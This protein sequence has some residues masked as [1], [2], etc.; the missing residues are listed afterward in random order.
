MENQSGNTL[1]DSIVKD[2]RPS[3]S[4]TPEGQPNFI[5]VSEMFDTPET[6][7]ADAIA[8]DPNSVARI[9]LYKTDIQKYGINAMASLGVAYP[10]FATDTYNPVAQQNPPD[11]TYSKL[12]DAF[13]LTDTTGDERVA[14]GFAGM[15]QT[16]FMRYY[17]HPDFQ[18]LGFSPYANMEQYYN[19]NSTVYDDMTRMWGEYT[20]LAGSGFSSVYR[21]IGDAF[22]GDSYWSA[23]DLESASEFQD[24]MGIGNS[25]RNGGMA[26]TNNFLLN[27]AYTVGILSSIAVEELAMA[28][29]T[30]ATGGAFAP[31]AGVKSA[32]NLKKAGMAF[33]NFFNVSRMVGTTADIYRTL[34][35]AEHAKSFYDAA[36][37][38]GKVLG[39]MFAPN[40]MYAL[41]NLKSAENATQN[42]VNLA[43]MSST[44]GGF[45]RD[46]R[47]VNYAMAESKMEAGMVYN[48]VMREGINVYNENDIEKQI[49]D[50]KEVR[51]NIRANSQVSADEM[52][53]IR[54]K[55][56]KAGFYTQM[57]NAPIIYASNWFV[58]GNAL[59]GFNKSLG[60]MMNDSFRK[61]LGGKILKTK[62]TK[63]ATGA[64]NKNVFEAAGSGPMGYFRSLRAAGIKGNLSGMAGASLR[65]FSNNV[66]EG[67]Q[68]VSQEAVSAATK[69]YFNAVLRDPMAGGIEL[70]NQMISSGM[71]HQLSGE[72]FSV[73]MS[74]FLMGGAIQAPQ[75]LFFQGVPAVFNAA[76]GKF[77]TEEM[78][79]KY[80]EFKKNKT[81]LVAEAVIGWN[82]AWNSQ[83]DDPG[84][85]FDQ[86]KFNFLIQKQVSDGMKTSAY[87]QDMFGFTDEKD[88]GKFIQINTL[89]R[90]GGI[91]HFTEQLEDYLKLSDEEL[92][93]AFPGEAKDIANGKIRKR[94]QDFINYA[95]KAE[96]N[97]QRLNDEYQNPHDPNSFKKGTREF[98]LEAM[99][100]QAYEHA[101]FLALYTQDNFERA[102]ERS[103]SIF[104]NLE[105][106]PLFEKMAAKDISILTS[107]DNID[108]EIQLLRQELLSTIQNEGNEVK[109]PNKGV[110]E[111]NKKKQEKITRLE[112]I[113]EILT[114]PKNLTKNGSFDRR[115][116]NKLRPEFKNYVRYLASTEGSFLERDKI[117][118]A[119]KQLVDYHALKGRAQVYDKAVEYLSNPERLTE[120]ADRTLA[121]GQSLFKNIKGSV[122][123]SIEK[124]LDIT[125]AN[126]LMN[127]L[128]ALGVYPDPAES[129]EFLT[130]GDIDNLKTFYNENGQIN[131]KVDTVIWTQIQNILTT[132]KGITQTETTEEKATEKTETETAEETRTDQN[133]ILNELGIQVEL[134]KSNDTP[135]LNELLERQYRKYKATQARLGENIL[136]YDEWRNSEVGLN[137]QNT[138]NALKKVWAS[139]VVMRADSEGNPFK[140]EVSRDNVTNEKGFKEWFGLREVKESAIVK[141]ILDSAGLDITDI[142]E[143]NSDIGQEGDK[144]KGSSNKKIYKRGVQANVIKITTKDPDT[145]EDVVLYKL[146]DSNGKNISSKLLELIDSKFGAYTSASSAIAALKKIEADAPNTSTFLFDEVELHQGELLFDKLGN[147]FIVLST[148]KQVQGGYLRIIEEANNTSNIKEREKSVI[149][150]QAGQLKGRYSLQ[151]IKTDRLPATTSRLDINDVV[152]P[153][154]YK[155][156]KE[157]RSMAAQRYN[158]IISMLTPAE[159]QMLELYIIPN[160]QAGQLGRYYAVESADG[161]VYKESNPYIRRIKSKYDIGVR[162]ADATVRNRVNN[163]L[164]KAG[165]QLSEN[166][167]NIFAY[168]P[169]ES[170]VFTDSQGNSIDPR[171]L[172]KEQALN[173]IYVPK[174]ISNKLTKEE[175]LTL[176]Q[177]NFALNAM[178]VTELD[179]M[180]ITEPRAMMLESFPKEIGL[181]I[182]GA[183]MAY[184]PKEL[185]EA[186]DLNDLNYQHADT[187]GNYL[188]YDLKRDKGGKGRTV[189]S[190]TN[191]EGKAATALRNKVKLSLEG[192][193]QWEAMLSGTDRYL[194]AVLLPNGKYGLV[195]L[196]PTKFSQVEIQDL[197]TELIE[198]AQLTQKENLDDKGEAKDE[199]Y[200]IQYNSDLADRLFISTKPGFIVALQVDPWGKIQMDVFDKNAKKQVGENITIGKKIINDKAPGTSSVKKIQTLI[201]LFNKDTEITLAGVQV[202]VN[203]LRR[204]FPDNAS[205]QDVIDDTQTN[206]LPSVIENQSLRI[207]ASSAD[208]QSSRDVGATI[209]NK[210][211]DELTPQNEFTIAEEAEESI[212]DLSDAQF[213]EQ[214]EEE[215][216]NFEKEFVGHMVN[217]ILRGQELSERETQAYK[218]LE[219]RVNMEVAKAG[220]AGSKKTA[221]DSII[222]PEESS[223][224]DNSPLN[225]AKLELEKLKLK[226][227]EGVDGRSKRKVLKES[228][229]YQKLKEKVKKLGK[230][231]NKILPTSQLTGLQIE[232][233]DAFSAWAQGALPSFI[234]IQDLTQL[235]NNQKAGGQRV[236]AFVMSLKNIAGGTTI[237]GTIYTGANSPFKYHEA[238]HGV[239]TMLLSQE[240]IV[241]YRGIARKEVRAKLRAEGKNFKT[242]L[243]IFRN[244]ADTYT[245]MTEKELMNEYYEEYLAD[246]FEVFKMSPKKTNTSPE[247]KSLFTK[248]LEFIK[249]IFSTRSQEELKVL[250]ENIDA[251]KYQNASL[252]S[253]EFTQSLQEGITLEKNA[254]VPY[255]TIQNEND[256]NVRTGYL[257]LDSDIADPMVR[258]IAAMYLDKTSKFTQPTY[259]PAV[260]IDELMDD[261]AWMYSPSNPNNENKSDIQIQKLEEIEQ[262][263]DIYDEEIKIEVVELLNVLG[264]QVN[265]E[266]Y[267]LDELEDE[268][269]L[270]ST[271]QYDIDASMIGGHTSLSAKL[272]TY[273]ATTTLSETDYFGNTELK[274]GVTLITAVD[275][276]DAYNGLLKAV[277]NISDPKRILQSMYFFGQENAQAGAVVRRLL[278]DVGISTEELLST[279]SLGNLS[280]PSLLQSIIKGFENFRVDYIF[281]ERDEA[282]NIRIYSA[283]ERDDINSQLDRWNQAWINRS[284]LLKANSTR[285]ETTRTML[286]E[287]QT[288]LDVSK[289]K[290]TNANLT[291]I[292]NDFSRKLFDLVGVRLSPLYL[293]YS[294]LQQR[295]Q[296]T[297]KQKALVDLYADETPLTADSIAQMDL[298]IQENGDIF[299]TVTGMDS[300]L[301]E[302]SIH[303]APFDETIGA[304]VFKNPNG[305]LVYAHQK[306][307]LHLKAVNDLN[308]ASILED[309]KVSDPYLANNFLLNSTAFDNLSVENRLKVLRIAGSKVG[310]RLASEE[311]LN[312][313]ISGVKSTQTYGD[314]TSKEFALAVINNYAALLNTKSNKVQ[315]VS[316][317]DAKGNKF[318]RA[319]AP[320][321]IR[322][323]EASNTGD[324][325]SLPVIKAVDFKAGESI[326]SDKLINIYVD[327]VKTEFARINREAFTMDS[328][329]ASNQVL[330]Y[331]TKDGR[332]FKFV[333]NGIV[334]SSEIQSQL[335]AI[336]IREGKAQNIVSLETAMKEVSNM[337]ALKKNIRLN[338]ETAFDEF[339]STLSELNMLDEISNNIL[340]GPVNAKGVQRKELVDSARLLNLNYDSTHNLKQ[341]FFNDWVN[342]GAINEIL[343]GDQAVTLSSMVDRVKRAKM[344][345]AAYDSAYSAIDA[346]SQGV[347]HN[348]EKISLITLEEP[349]GS[350]S[351]TGKNIDKADAQMYI[352]TKAFRYLRFGFGRLSNSQA[353][354]IDNIEAGQQITSEDIFG[355]EFTSEGFAKKQELLNSKKLV[356][357]DGTTFL[358][359]SAFILTPEY[360]SLWDN[361]N[362]MWVAKPHRV[363]LHNLRVKLEAIENEENA[364]TLGIAAPLTAIKM[365]K[366]RVNQLVELDNANPFTNAPT[367]LDAR[368]MGLQVINKSNKLEILDTTQI[369]QI[370]TSEQN[371]KTYVEALK[372]NVGQIR[373]AYNTAV[374]KRVILNYK[375]KRNLVFTLDTALDELALSEKE[376]GVTP[377]LAA[378]LNYAKEGLKA[379]K[380]SQ[381]I[382]DFFSTTDGVQNYDL[383]NPLTVQK[384]EQLFLAYFSRG[385]LS[386][387]APGS[388]LTLLS[389]FGSQIYR[390]VYEVETKEI[391][392]EFITTPVR[393]EVI[394]ENDFLKNYSVS[395]LRDLNTITS[396]SKGLSQG[397]IV[398]DDLRH[399]LMEYT[400][401][402]DKESATG[403]RYTEM[404]MPAHYKSVMDLIENTPNAKLPD[405]I[406]KMFGVR[407]PSQDNHSAVNM[408]MVDFMP[409]YYGSTAMFAQELIE[410]SGADFDIDK[411][412]ALM[413]EFYVEEGEFKEYGTG[414]LYKEYINYTN[415]KANQYGTIYSEALSLFAGNELAGATDLTD[416]QIKSAKKA[417]FENRTIKALQTLGLPITS[418]QFDIYN[419]KHGVPFAAPLNNEILDYR[420]AMIGNNG[421]SESKDNAVPISYQA[422]NTDVLWDP[423]TNTGV[424]AE[425]AEVSEV[426][427]NR[428]EEENIDVDNLTGKIKA[429]TANKGASI[430]AVVLPNLYL[431]LLTEYKTIVKP[432]SALYINGK[433]Y[434]KYGKTMLEG[435]GRKQ[436]V[437]SAL[438]TMATDNAKDRLVAKLG[439][440]RHAV[441]LLTN[442]TAL[443]VPIKTSLLLI[444][445]PVIVDL[446]NQALNKKNKLDAGI[447]ALVTNRIVDL[448]S[449]AEQ[450]G[451]K[452][453]FVTVNNELLID[454][455]NNPEDVSDDEMYSILSLFSKAAALQKFTGKMSAPTSLTKGLGS[456][457]AE[458]N[459]K[460]T[461]MTELFDKDAP[462]DLAPIYKGK[463]WQNTYLKIF[464]QIT[465]KLLPAT[466][467]SASSGFKSI[468]NPVLEQMDTNNI[469]FTEEVLAKVRLDLLSYLTIKAFQKNGLDNNPQSVAT[470]SN[471]I[472]YPTDLN[473]IVDVIERLRT[474]EAGQDNFF[475]DNYVITTEA[476][477][478]PSG[479]NQANSNTFRQ[480]NSGQK[481]ELQNDFAK[482]YGSL[483]TRNDAMTI[484]NYEMVK[485]GLQLG[486][487]SILSVMSP[488]ALTTYLDQIPS[489]EKA[490][491]GELKYESVFGA[492]LQEIMKDFSEGYLISNTNNSKLFTF[493]TDQITPLPSNLRLNRETNEASDSSGD[494]LKPPRKYFRIGTSD[495]MGGTIYRTYRHNKEKS[496]ESVAIYDEVDTMGSNQQNGIGF[497]FGERPTYKEVRQYVR[498][499][500]GVAGIRGLDVAKIE[501]EIKE[502]SFDETKRIQT[503]ALQNDNSI[504][505]A[506][507]NEVNISYDVEGNS[508]NIS[509]VS[510]L[511]SQIKSD[512][513]AVSETEME[514]NVIED[515]DQ[516]MPELSPEQEQLTLDLKFELSDTYDF[517]TEEFDEIVKDKAARLALMNQNLF[518]LSNMIEAYESRFSKN[519]TQSSEESQKD[520]IDNIKRC[521]L[522]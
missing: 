346:P 300:R 235:A 18:Q 389:D 506:N 36:K 330:G 509:D 193:G 156:K 100:Y 418:S 415:E 93:Q 12:K 290:L 426:F 414:N 192:S 224:V 196:K 131:P 216:A 500:G 274:D 251:G 271:S 446:Y 374:S 319:L 50:G 419:N 219:S 281:N 280:N 202:S 432:K 133:D 488:V 294:I 250:F 264:D 297:V 6:L 99:K 322:V 342:T 174:A 370:I 396:E 155:N 32:L 412:F 256:G 19:A 189:Q 492:N 341:I 453:K 149:K 390:R 30:V 44:F 340:E 270:R 409:A 176:A 259:S 273:I 402:K 127:Q 73:F 486:Y 170:Y 48:D 420:Y 218:F 288:Y 112:K 242:E 166:Q 463:T 337:N 316:G 302:M 369:K 313:N 267:T 151:E 40:T 61:G 253:N 422:A 136:L 459:Q 31:V 101:K 361:T 179:D 325:I 86:S 479:F 261:F 152:S 318:K 503:D 516:A 198:R 511:L 20:S 439:L 75:K 360:T 399:G 96:S 49:V 140:E 306:P 130:T 67:I 55:S 354:L 413:K 408:K 321:L 336:A 247:V 165:F 60:R 480:L 315:T 443:A 212:L 362:Q 450:Q 13:T 508:V 37:T 82:K 230:I 512:S 81:D 266:E 97:Y 143:S 141:R 213:D 53:I 57:A 384:A 215:F 107:I 335:S 144:F 433:T 119:L 123:E 395:D 158:H 79:A 436:D 519:S 452:R 139:G 206:V 85:I 109:L 386:E 425:L 277:K 225:K 357:A 445:N 51:V 168:L 260:V 3:M 407:I 285:K 89:L 98:A 379:S 464:V 355:S 378:F 194:A 393:S 310:E 201:D 440:N 120:I 451:E 328:L 444:N 289:K 334:F 410:V 177:D 137:F 522:K 238:F 504:I 398:L 441:G 520:F 366:Q 90:Q 465:N 118:D 495:V 376:G 205:V 487:G 482:L 10:S 64:I 229:E 173:T 169:N 391:N 305:D 184:G 159:L 326:L 417:G 186:R 5:P 371:D 217:K 332:A 180:N 309:L 208:I 17:N 377:N 329:D 401:P 279:A 46:V 103:N 438:I 88:L 126:E 490:L 435:G 16:Q 195:N 507:E 293:Q 324:L 161:T 162:I 204:S 236:G 105:N 185:Q 148:P 349:I 484:V 301:K 146:I 298:I 368:Y 54:D 472:I 457:I 367:E 491:R 269:G 502:M 209:N 307:T 21:S 327:R 104:S 471:D 364:Q 320:V 343:L 394:R 108:R 449:E 28:G 15:R 231:S 286:A 34:R 359:M 182:G 514:A 287:F 493:E 68:E 303:S 33:V 181:T 157:S 314:F 333:N 45:Y 84:A 455:L 129:K 1:K 135:M 331:N 476:S 122:K 72:G 499:N 373:E 145:G 25:S 59:G 80:E 416:A 62:A 106:E 35:N 295:P 312:E 240:E 197:Y 154:P 292:S 65:Y 299:D 350:S 245:D 252:A 24:A 255:A 94:I 134:E 262:A 214:L 38:G 163:S 207:T 348:V 363:K 248:I 283:A 203:N 172:T 39:T 246:Q 521:I 121:F 317:I 239:F 125:V 296:S 9:D 477:D 188:V 275:F 478:S 447:E 358:K 388:T 268:T 254:L 470:L 496:S 241:K 226:L 43:K 347:V 132:Y 187:E 8:I 7:L 47:M 199:G 505:T 431:S 311:D 77:G 474:T 392:G 483:E 352:T 405:V 29:A 462:M 400:D 365:K 338:L 142:I 26:W 382:L 160:P 4:I 498:D 83:V 497:M 461:D 42:G 489:V 424:L 223:K 421:V 387:K 153:Y 222:E 63:S 232:E 228:E 76:K 102:L 430:G 339:L 344:Q 91:N 243:E 95:D 244:S 375:N 406:S 71:G 178:L 291:T 237:D 221:F 258:S 428:I 191:L 200:N 2:Q 147:K 403:L 513:E 265:T 190:K 78:K 351:I 183:Q 115:K 111:T 466:F 117:D 323:M 458:L 74:G 249:G 383:N 510:Q 171:N 429:F 70:R 485:G 356:Y 175:A 434:N 473:S 345:N 22:D 448:V 211:E 69:G 276:I 23:P 167:D 56:S 381:Q 66:A 124:Y 456:S 278:Q 442:M 41:K 284:K 308:N 138:F 110:G 234:T 372:L 397:I 14:P 58:L 385:V 469:D 113:R 92:V 475:L 423:K 27:S 220:G 128:A 272:K 282:G 52:T 353:Q 518:P 494:G 467:I 257:Y 11:N 411:V 501:Q 263:F 164:L 227:T 233:I 380:S 454:A 515:V 150:I 437:L 460:Y 468:L 404:I 116:I 517:I 210:R 114:E 304:S 87:D 427:K 481:I